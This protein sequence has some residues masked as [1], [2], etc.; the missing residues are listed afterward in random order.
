MSKPMKGQIRKPK[1]GYDAFV[2]RIQPGRRE[3]THIGMRKS[4]GGVKRAQEGRRNRNRAHGSGGLGR[5][6]DQGTVCQANPLVSDRYYLAVEVYVTPPQ[7]AYLASAQAEEEGKSQGKPVRAVFECGK[8]GPHIII[9]PRNGGLLLVR[10]AS[11]LAKIKIVKI[12]EG[13]PAEHV[14]QL[15]RA[16]FTTRTDLCEE[17]PDIIGTQGVYR[18]RAEGGYNVPGYKVP[19][20][21]LCSRLQLCGP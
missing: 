4:S 7:A 14:D 19:V 5:S 16:G 6:V 17:V 8:V 2:R 3:N 12:K 13:A 15:R 21:F 11:N 20:L 1:P 10:G 18:D 9:R